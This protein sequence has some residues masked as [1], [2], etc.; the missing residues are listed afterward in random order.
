MGVC[1]GRQ[2]HI[3]N[4]GVSSG[5]VPFNPLS[6]WGSPK[7]KGTAQLFVGVFGVA[8][9]KGFIK[10]KGMAR[11]FVFACIVLMNPHLA[12]FW[13]HSVPILV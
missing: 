3:L 4:P 1:G 8:K 5:R 13:G 7:T 12:V 10:T 9:N 2:K 6:V 11:L